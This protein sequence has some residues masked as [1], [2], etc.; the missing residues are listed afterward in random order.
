MYGNKLSE[1][2]VQIIETCVVMKMVCLCLLVQKKPVF[3][4]TA[5]GMTVYLLM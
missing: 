1:R 2:Y 4:L 3:D 5:A